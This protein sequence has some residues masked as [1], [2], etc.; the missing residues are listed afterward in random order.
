MKALLQITWVDGMKYKPIKGCPQK[1][2]FYYH[3]GVISAA[4]LEESFNNMGISCPRG[5]FRRG[6]T[7]YQLNE[8]ERETAA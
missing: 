6:D 4:L 1:A 2:R 5:D 7:R 8:A 3:K